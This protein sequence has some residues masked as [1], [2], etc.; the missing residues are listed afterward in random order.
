MTAQINDSLVNA[1]QL[2][3]AFNQYQRRLSEYRVMMFHANRDRTICEIDDARKSLE[4]VLATTLPNSSQLE[5]MLVALNDQGRD[6]WNSPYFS[7]HVVVN[8][9]LEVPPQ[10]ENTFLG[11][12]VVWLRNQINPSACREQMEPNFTDAFTLPALTE[13]GERAEPSHE[14]AWVNRL[15][16][17]LADPNSSKKT[18]AAFDLA[19]CV[20]RWAYPRSLT[21]A[22]EELGITM[23]L[24]GPA[25]W[26]VND[27]QRLA[28]QV[29]EHIWDS[30]EEMASMFSRQPSSQLEPPDRTDPPRNLSADGREN[31]SRSDQRACIEE[32]CS[33]VREHSSTN[34]VLRCTQRLNNLGIVWVA[35]AFGFSGQPSTSRVLLQHYCRMLE[36]EIAPVNWDM[37]TIRE[38]RIL[39]GDIHTQFHAQL[40]NRTN[41]T[42]TVAKPKLRIEGE[43]LHSDAS[44]N[45]VTVVCLP[46]FATKQRRLIALLIE[47]DYRVRMPAVKVALNYASEDLV[48]DR[49]EPSNTLRRDPRNVGSTIKRAGETIKPLGL[50]IEIDKEF[51]IC[52]N[53]S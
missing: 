51:V 26:V 6:F 40:R 15:R 30:D 3:V 18:Q 46:N 14:Q 52:R 53:R 17:E 27:V 16:A 42:S 49:T 41:C 33:Q 28:D 25:C 21:G 48:S 38:R 43:N 1:Y 39:I 7:P 10:S 13:N 19:L 11:T 47:N 34:K 37:D 31:S 8:E 36:I 2:G 5:P 29:F 50:A 9:S 12:M 4:Y 35:Q 20:D 45:G 44:Q 32:F 24:A 23:E 22:F